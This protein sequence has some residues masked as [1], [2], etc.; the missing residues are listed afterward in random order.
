MTRRFGVRV[1]PDRCVG[2]AMCRAALPDVFVEDANGQSVVVG[3]PPTLAAA[4]E[5]A[6]DCPV[7]AILVEDADTGEPIDS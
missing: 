1:D 4:L 6:A 2:N 7:G 3:A 5:A